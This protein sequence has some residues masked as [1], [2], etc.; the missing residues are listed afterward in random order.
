MSTNN[1][2]GDIEPQIPKQGEA[3][4]SIVTKSAYS[5]SVSVKVCTNTGKVKLAFKAHNEGT[6]NLSKI[7]A[8][9]MAGNTEAL[10]YIPKYIDLEYSADG[11][12]TWGT[13]LRKAIPLTGISYYEDSSLASTNW[14]TVGTG[15]IPYSY[16]L[17]SISA[18]SP[19][20]FRLV[21]KS[22]DISSP[23]VDRALA[24]FY[25]ITAEQLSAVT[26]GTQA[27]IQWK[28]QLLHEED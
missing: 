9:L 13:F 27:I 22:E 19:N 17:E 7:F 1:F 5:G 23:L 10:A 12:A 16:F 3:N 2:L 4:D 26:S 11:G 24:Y 20:T 28:L 18:T 14:V 21:L 25:N 15:V 6:I 8:M